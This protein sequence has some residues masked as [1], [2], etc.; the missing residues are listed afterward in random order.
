VREQI[1]NCVVTR[2]R[3]NEHGRCALMEVV[4]VARPRRS[5][6]GAVTLTSQGAD[7]ASYDPK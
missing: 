2:C 1:V 4:I 6:S 3:Y 7:C 5:E